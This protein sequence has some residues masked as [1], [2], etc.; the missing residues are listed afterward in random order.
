MDRHLP[1]PSLSVPMCSGYCPRDVTHL[2]T[3]VIEFIWSS[4]FN[5]EGLKL[6][7]S[8]P[9]FSQKGSYN[10]AFNE[11]DCVRAAVDVQR[12]DCT[13]K[14]GDEGTVVHIYNEGEAF[15]V[16]FVIQEAGEVITMYPNELEAL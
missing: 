1:Q 11:H 9:F 13:V 4:T 3:G 15:L 8:D 2:W 16:E 14:K 5:G 10:M 6:K 7:A 12:Q